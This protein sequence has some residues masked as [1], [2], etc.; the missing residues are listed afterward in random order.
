MF[1]TFE[2]SSFFFSGKV[3]TS[4]LKTRQSIGNE[5][6]NCC[7]IKDVTVFWESKLNLE[8]S[9]YETDFVRSF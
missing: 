2:N 7:S 1:L 4:F 9:L 5:M 6:K 3:E 8:N